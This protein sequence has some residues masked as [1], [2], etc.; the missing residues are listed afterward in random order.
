MIP[1]SERTQSAHG[2]LSLQ[3]QHVNKRMK[4][5]KA[6]QSSRRSTEAFICV[7]STA[8]LK[9]HHIER[10]RASG[11]REDG[12]STATF[13]ASRREQQPRLPDC[14]HSCGPS[15]PS[16]SSLAAKQRTTTGCFMSARCGCSA[17]PNPSPR[18]ER[19]LRC[20]R[21]T[22][23]V[24]FNQTQQFFNYTWPS[25]SLSPHT[26]PLSHPPTLLSLPSLSSRM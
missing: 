15:P 25:L 3:Q 23:L 16:P 20:C 13:V 12:V 7:R 9:R 1:L 17:A 6:D 4:R 21:L 10:E 26:L 8:S 18:C 11:R 14:Y 5:K 24:R 19:S 2:S 22:N